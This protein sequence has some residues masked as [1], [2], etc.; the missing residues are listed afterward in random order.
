[1]QVEINVQVPY[2]CTKCLYLIVMK[3]SV[4]DA[5]PFQPIPAIQMPMLIL[6]KQLHTIDNLIF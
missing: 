6:L 3:Y 5:S 2:L 4:D 1:M